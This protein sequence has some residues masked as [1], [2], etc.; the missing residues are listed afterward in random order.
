MFSGEKCFKRE[1]FNTFAV[2]KFYVVRTER[3][4]TLNKVFFFFIK[5]LILNDIW[6]RS[7]ILLDGSFF[8]NNLTINYIGELEDGER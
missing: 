2:S 7:V 5:R 8:L 1:C 4:Q 3:F 6:I